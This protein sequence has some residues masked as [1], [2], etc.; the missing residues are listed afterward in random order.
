MKEVPIILVFLALLPAPKQT[1]SHLKFSFNRFPAKKIPFQE[2]LFTN[3]FFL[4][5]IIAVPCFS[6]GVNQKNVTEIANDVS[7]IPMKKL[8]ILSFRKN[9]QN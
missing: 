7:S 6:G 1:A 8:K 5:G 2:N 3:A 4:Q 9:W